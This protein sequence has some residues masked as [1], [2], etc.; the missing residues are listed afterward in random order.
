MRVVK[1]TAAAGGSDAQVSTVPA[2]WSLIRQCLIDAGWT[3]HDVITASAD[4]VFTS[5]GESLKERMYFRLSLTDTNTVIRFI[6]YQY[7]DAVGHA[8]YNK[9]GEYSGAGRTNYG[10]LDWISMAANAYDYCVVA[11]KDGF[12]AYFRDTVSAVVFF[13]T[14]GLLIRMREERKDCVKTTGAITAGSSVVLTTDVDMAGLGYKIGDKINILNQGTTTIGTNAAA[15]CGVIPTVTTWIEG[16]PAANQVQVNSIP[17]NLDAG[18]LV[19][20]FPMPVF[21]IHTNGNSYNLVYNNGDTIRMMRGFNHSN[22]GGLS[23]L[24]TG[25][26]MHIGHPGRPGGFMS[27]ADHDPNPR[28]GRNGMSR[29]RYVYPYG[30]LAAWGYLQHC[31]IYHRAVTLYDLARTTKTTPV[32]DYMIFPITTGG[33]TGWFTIGPV[34]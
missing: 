25:T 13:Q 29:I 4:E 20:F 22:T 1:R 21:L 6:F 27:S 5:D 8:G 17:N 32:R 18:A 24:T 34:N 12:A 3:S 14:G 16:F 2:V 30:E 15:N 28:T 7:W 19:G 31:F 23:Y 26:D 10:W 33:V 11:D 9:F